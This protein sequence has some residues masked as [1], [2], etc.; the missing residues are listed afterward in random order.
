MT[1]RLSDL[2][3]EKTYFLTVYKDLCE[4]TLGLQPKNFKKIY[5]VYI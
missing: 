1:T 3:L 4:E 2:H 5:D